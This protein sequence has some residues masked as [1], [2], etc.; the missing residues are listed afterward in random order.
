MKKL[1]IWLLVFAALICGGLYIG[2]VVTTDENTTEQVI[3]NDSKVLNVEQL[4]AADREYMFLNYGGDYRWYETTI[5]M[6]DFL[7]E[8][9]TGEIE[10]VES[11]FQVMTDVD[12]T[13]ANVNV[14]YF[15]HTLE[16]DTIIIEDGFWVGDA[17]LNDMK[18]NLTYEDAFNRAMETNCVKP[19]S[20]YCVL[21]RFIG[22]TTAVY[23]FGND[24][25]GLLFV[26]AETSDVRCEAPIIEEAA[27][28]KTV[29]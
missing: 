16:N 6:K 29:K 12:S 26:N 18:I 22:D 1:L 25:K 5:L 8:E 2:D 24:Y 15:T 11:L 17:P 4:V 14:I 13:S 3:E 7:D 21:R 20:K 10:S 27:E 9:T 19:N 28:V 23:I